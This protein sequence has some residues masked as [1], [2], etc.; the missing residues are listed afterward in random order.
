MPLNKGCSI[1]ALR[2]NISKLVGEGYP[3][4]QAVAA[5]METLRSSCKKLD[6][7]M[8]DMG[9][10]VPPDF[11]DTDLEAVVRVLLAKEAE[12]Q[13]RA[14]DVWGIFDFGKES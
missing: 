3:Q 13:G 6:K 9:E 5:A 8:P 11:D 14:T 2:E 7:P 1:S 12:K 10:I 4:D